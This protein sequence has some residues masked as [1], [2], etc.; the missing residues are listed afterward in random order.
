MTV[1]VWDLVHTTTRSG[2]RTIRG[3]LG[4]RFD[5]RPQAHRYKFVSCNVLN[6]SPPARFERLSP[7]TE[8]DDEFLDGCGCGRSSWVSV[9][10]IPRRAKGDGLYRLFASELFENA[11]NLGAAR[12]RERWKPRRRR[13]LLAKE[14][15]DSDAQED[16]RDH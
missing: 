1:R 14:V 5:A 8:N 12:R 4:R 9:K 15:R 6:A 10:R 7:K 2:S 13:C 3:V 16:G 11:R